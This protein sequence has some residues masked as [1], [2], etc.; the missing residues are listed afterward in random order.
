MADLPPQIDDNA[1]FGPNEVSKQTIKDTSV[2]ADNAF[3]QA[4]PGA[5]NCKAIC[6]IL[7]SL[8]QE[9]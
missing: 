2:G 1:N 8:Q 6:R 7:L 5:L 9:Q 3:D 4:A